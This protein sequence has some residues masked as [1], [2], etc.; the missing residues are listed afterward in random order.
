MGRRIRIRELKEQA[1]QTMTETRQLV[2]QAKGTL[3]VTEK[4]L[5]KLVEQMSTAIVAATEAVDEVMDGLE[6]EGSV[7]IAGKV[8][9]IK[10]RVKIKFREEEPQP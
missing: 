10:G 1:Q 6:A 9:P 2:A 5:L 7:E 8:L 3:T 4:A